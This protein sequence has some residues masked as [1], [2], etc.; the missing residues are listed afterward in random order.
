[1]NYVVFC[2]SSALNLSIAHIIVFIVLNLDVYCEHLNAKFVPRDFLKPMLCCCF[3]C[4]TPVPAGRVLCQL[5][6]C[7]KEEVDEAVQSAHEAYKKW[8]EMSGMERARVMLE[9]ARI[10]RVSHHA[11]SAD[12]CTV[13][14]VTQ[15]VGR[16]GR[17]GEVTHCRLNF[18]LHG[19][20]S[21]PILPFVLDNETC[22]N[23]V[24]ALSRLNG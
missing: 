20:L 14:S 15:H 21:N 24:L 4:I 22:K 23:F 18:S 10:I 3:F 13:S 8:R 2:G 16:C 7:G 6:P 9:A 17:G 11:V 1:M 12:K 5:C 19:L